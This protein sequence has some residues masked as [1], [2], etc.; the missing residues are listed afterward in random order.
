[1]VAAVWAGRKGYPW[2]IKRHWGWW[3]HFPRMTRVALE[4][5]RGLEMPLKLY[6][7]GLDLPEQRRLKE[8]AATVLAELATVHPD[9]AQST[10][11]SFQR[12][13]VAPCGRRWLPH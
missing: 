5:S 13:H 9:R 11:W 7:P 10:Q 1:M 12:H 6:S 2:A 4:W 3:R 8:E